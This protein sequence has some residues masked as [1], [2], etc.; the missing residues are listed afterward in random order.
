MIRSACQFARTLAKWGVF[1]SLFLPATVSAQTDAQPTADLTTIQHFVFIIKENRTFDNYFGTYPGADGVTS[2]P[3][4]TGQVI[5]LGRTPDVTPR[6]IG[7]S[8]TNAIQS[9]DNGRMDRFDTIGPQV[10]A[11]NINGDMLC[12]TQLQQ[13]DIPNYF[14]YAQHFVL[15]D[16]NFSSQHGMSL[17]NHLYTIAAQSGGVI[18]NGEPQPSAGC[19]AIPS[20]TV[21]VIDSQGYVTNQFP[22]FNM[23]TL[24]DVM[25][26]AGVSWRYYTPSHT[27]WNPL[28]AIDHIRNSTLWNTNVSPD[29]QFATDAFNGNLPAVSWVVPTGTASEHPPQSSCLGENWAVQQINAVMQGP[30]WATTAIFL[31]WDD[32]GGFYDH[33]PPP[34]ID[35][36]GLGPRVPLLII[37]PYAKAGY[38]S[39]TQ[40]EL[41]SLLK[42]VEERFNLAPLTQRDTIANDMLD[43]F[44]F[45]QSPLPPLLLS[46]R[47]CS[48]VSTT[49]FNFPP[50]RVGQPSAPKTVTINNVNNVKLNVSSVVL[51]GA[52]Y[53]M[54]APCGN[55]P[56]KSSC[57]MSVVFTP[58]TS[59]SR[60]GTIT[61][62][63]S[64][65]TSPQ[66][67]NLNG[68]GTS[69]VLSPALVNF[70]ARTVGA[71][72]TPKTVTLTNTGTD[73]LAITNIAVTGDYSQINTCGSGVTGG[74]SC[75]ISVKFKP[76][77]TGVRYGA[78]TINDADGGSP[79]LVNL[80]GTGSYVVVSPAKLNFGNL[81]VGGSTAPLT[82]TLTNVGTSPL[83]ISSVV[84]QDSLAHNIPDYVQTNNCGSSVAPGANC[85]FSVTFS[86]RSIGKLPGIL[87]I[88]DSE[89]ET[90]PVQIALQGTSLSG[91]LVSLSPTSLSFA[92]Q[93]VGTT[94]AS[95][96]VALTNTGV[97]TLNI[98]SIATSG[99][100]SQT[101]NC[102][103]KVAVGVNCT[104]TVSFS[105]TVA[106]LGTGAVTITDDA[107][108]SPQTIGLSGNGSAPGVGLN[109]TSLAF[110]DQVVGSISGSLPIT[111]TNTGT[112]TLN[113]ASIVSS[114]HFAQTNNCGA[115]VA[116]TASCTVTVSF[117]PTQPGPESGSITITDDAVPSPQVVSLSGNG[118]APGVMLST[119]SLVFPDQPQGTTS[120]PLPVTLTNTGTSALNI[121]S[122]VSAGDF[123]QT[124]DC[125]SVVGVGAR[126]TISVTFTPTQLGAESGS[127]TVTDDATGSPQV[128]SL[129][130][131]GT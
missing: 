116:A 55:V 117:S 95:Q 60:T 33:V 56:P 9:W 66:V 54:S 89:V 23:T 87:Q 43:S 3:I 111:L 5:P 61:I 19:D 16:R 129:S 65:P 86:P 118:V 46:T 45:N 48:P 115:T 70:G 15:A 51:S 26:G 81:K 76:L 75:T 21:K 42:I 124:N 114:G 85:T 68:T 123:A 122:I 28:D 92:D 97:A 71:A 82:L 50:Q 62:T 102:G 24:A 113:I 22:C 101:N 127:V 72:G 73:P 69:V 8:W 77:A 44:D 126:C 11:C 36:E 79:H 88:F 119:T 12:Y 112:A 128:I 1:A 74:G 120:S 109:P 103:N 18:S 27:I 106:G 105:P 13:Q 130:G 110:G 40:Y 58:S 53:S 100:F 99:D 34:Q 30:D 83:G 84:P 131:N 125:G 91:P 25:E 39:H 52:D 4:S 38:I 107:G 37:S 108:N 29:T 7:H 20:A 90:S 64:D 78:V 80:T 121:A 96:D 6:D 98:S 2:G 94:S 47:Q 17:P 67:V 49:T 57:N 63:D 32:F 104:I 10:S 14:A 41:S 59:G 35:Q 31:V 93:L